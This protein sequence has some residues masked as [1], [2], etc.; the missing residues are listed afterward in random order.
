MTFLEPL[1]LLLLVVPGLL[2]GVYVVMRLRQARY[3]VRFTNLALLEKVVPVRPGWRRHLPAA[4]FLLMILVCVLGFARPAADVRVPREQAT[5]M[6]AV[7]VSNSMEAT[8]VAPSRLAA[9]QR[10]A[11]AFL[12]ELPERFNVGLVTFAGSATVV[13]PPTTDRTAVRAAIDGLRLS[14]RT[15]IGEAVFTSLDELSRFGAQWGRQ[16]PPARIVLLSDG[17]NTAGRLPGVAAQEAAARRVPVSTIAYGTPGGVIW[18]EGSAL[19]VP[20]DGPALRRL[21][22]QTG[23]RFYEAASGAELSRVYADIGSSIGHRTERREVWV[24]FVGAALVLGCA[25]AAGSLLWFS[26]LP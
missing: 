15:A 3:A 18:S 19:P 24:W 2:L 9:A 6:M 21:A 7:D 11:R 25:A 26:R 8:D 23:G 12:G 4:A 10:A 1:R 13:V 14:P 17:E 20:V 22:E 16:A 5:I